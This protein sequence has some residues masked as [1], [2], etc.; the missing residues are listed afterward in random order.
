M[1]DTLKLIY[2]PFAG[3]G[4]LARMIAHAGGLQLEEATDVDDK[5]AF[6]SPGSLPLLSHGSLKIAQ[7]FAI[8]TYLA[9]I[10]PKFKGLTL[11]Q[12][13]KDA[14]FCAMK[15]DVLAGCAKIVW[16][17]LRHVSKEVGKHCD[18]WFT[19]L[20]GLLPEEG[21]INGLSFPTPADLAVLNMGVAY[22]PFGCAYK[23]GKY[24]YAAKY[25]KM[26]ALVDRTAAAKEIKQ[27]LSDS[28]TKDAAPPGM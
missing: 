20:E 23:H 15:E 27:Y 12:K 2:F 1:G 5:A 19:V 17:E 10:A 8:E 28:K 14:M 16:G 13:A 4:E 9:S 22:M 7:S 21:F 26:K 11:Q 24:S 18:N 25:P 6:G 3:R